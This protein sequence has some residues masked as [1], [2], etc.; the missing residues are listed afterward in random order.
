[1]QVTLELEGKA[2]KYRYIC[3]WC[4]YLFLKQMYRW[5]R[6]FCTAKNGQLTISL[7]SIFPKQKRL[8]LYDLT[9]GIIFP[10]HISGIEMV[11]CFK[12]VRIYFIS[13]KY[14]TYTSGCQSS[15]YTTVQCFLC[16]NYV[17]NHICGPF[18]ACIRILQWKN[19]C[20]K[21]SW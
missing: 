11:T 17:Q 6:S 18:M 1:M 16:H 8:Y 12:V 5:K 14:K 13:I 9:L 2:M 10:A 21:S 20:S 4:Q 19:G 15:D 3:R 7:Y